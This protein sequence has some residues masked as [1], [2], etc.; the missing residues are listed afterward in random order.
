MADEHDLP[1]EA[2]AGS[3]V[4]DEAPP[5]RGSVPANKP[6]PVIDSKLA[7]V[8]AKQSR[9]E[10]LSK[11]D[12]EIRLAYVLAKQARGEKLN[13]RER[14]CLGATRTHGAPRKVAPIVADNILLD[15]Q[16]PPE[17]ELFESEDLAA[18]PV[19]KA[20]DSARCR[21][22]ADALLTATDLG[23][24]LYIGWEAKRAE[25][26]K[27]TCDE[28]K[29]AVALQDGNRK[30]MLDGSEPIVLWLCK[31]FKCEPEQLEAVMKSSG[32]VGGAA[33]H[34]LGVVTAVKSIRESKKEKV[35]ATTVGK[36]FFV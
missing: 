10:K 3:F 1:A 21:A 5:A 16:A 35:A 30:L 6:E 29:A 25:A 36:T 26:D 11:A 2:D 33:M 17:N 9:G 7:A 27:Q 8:F 28:Y 23:G 14:G 4:A 15:V 24:Q 22:A 12:R 32:F 19:D 34:I 18:V 13:P 31:T 20:F